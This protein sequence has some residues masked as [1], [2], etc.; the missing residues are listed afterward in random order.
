M[1]MPELREVTGLDAGD[2][3]RTYPVITGE[4]SSTPAWESRPVR[5]GAPVAKPTPVFTKLDESVVSEE[6]AEVEGT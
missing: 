3:G 5:V 2:E 4:Y 6:L 1:P